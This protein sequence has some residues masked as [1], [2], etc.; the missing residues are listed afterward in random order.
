MKRVTSPF[1]PAARA[2]KQRRINEANKQDDGSTSDGRVI[3]NEILNDIK[4][5]RMNL[6]QQQSDSETKVRFWF[7]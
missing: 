2:N 6:M 1:T 3:V 4:A 7:F 5:T